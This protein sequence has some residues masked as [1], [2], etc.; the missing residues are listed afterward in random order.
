[1]FGLLNKIS[2]KVTIMQVKTCRLL[3][4]E[5]RLPEPDSLPP[6]SETGGC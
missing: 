3:V 2:A 6:L 1:M 4:K 5:K